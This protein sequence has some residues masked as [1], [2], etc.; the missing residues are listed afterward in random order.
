MVAGPRHGELGMRGDK[1]WIRRS[2]G[3][4]QA[5]PCGGLGDACARLLSLEL[6]PLEPTSVGFAGGRCQ[7]LA[8]G[9]RLSPLVQPVDGQLLAQ[10]HL[11]VGP[12]QPVLREDEAALGRAAQRGNAE[13]RGALGRRRFGRVGPRGLLGRRTRGLRCDALPDDAHIRARD[14]R[15]GEQH[16]HLVT[17][18]L[19]QADEVSQQVTDGNAACQ[20]VVQLQLLRDEHRA[21]AGHGAE[22]LHDGRQD[23]RD[24]EDDAAEAAEE[25][26]HPGQ[27]AVGRRWRHPVLGDLAAARH[28]GDLW[29]FAGGHRPR[30]HARWR[31]RRSAAGA[32]ETKGGG[33]GERKLGPPP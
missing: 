28:G 18:G 1:Q 12:L 13:L 3:G 15:E 27:G 23:A 21:D 24:V 10:A 17:N 25:E 9:L 2:H 22:E 8:E 11:Q 26:Q 4:G 30:R 33:G 19:P 31:D 32:L 7:T 6:R 14:V 5:R 16:H 20:L 29:R